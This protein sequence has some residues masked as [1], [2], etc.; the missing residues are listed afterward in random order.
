MQRFFPNRIHYLR[1]QGFRK[2]NPLITIA[3]FTAFRRDKACF[4]T[5]TQYLISTISRPVALLAIFHMSFLPVVLPAQGNCDDSQA[6]VVFI[7]GFL[8]SGD[9]WTTQIQRFASN[10]HCQDRYFAFDWNTLSTAGADARLDLF[11]DSVLSVTGADKIHLVGHSAGG[12]RGYSYLSDPARA[13]KVI[14]Y[15][16]IGSSAESGPAGPNGSTPTLN[17]WSTADAIANGTD[18]PGAENIQFTTFD[19]YQVATSAAT[20]SALYEFF[21][22]MAPGTSEI[23]PETIITIGGRCI[24][25]GENA[26]TTGAMIEVFSV[27]SQG[28]PE[29]D[30]LATFNVTSDGFWGPL[31]V[32]PNTYHLFK[33][34]SA[35]SGFRKVIYYYEPF[36]RDNPTVYLRTFPPALSLA[37][38]LLSAI[39]NSDNQSVISIF[40]STQ[41]VIH[42]RDELS[43]DG[44]DLANA[45]L[46]PASASM[47]A[48]F[49]YDDGGDGQGNG[50]PMGTFAIVPFLQG[51]DVPIAPDPGKTWTIT[52]NGSSIPVRN[53]R[54]K[55]DGVVIAVFNEPKTI[56]NTKSEY[57]GNVRLIIQ[58]NP[59]VDQA[60]LSMGG[61]K[62]NPADISIQDLFGRQL[63]IPITSVSEEELM[64]DITGIPG[65]TYI[66]INHRQ[67]G[68]VTGALLIKP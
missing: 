49:C 2:D 52:F 16:H 24:S 23:E 61:S 45:N 10:G 29:G 48:L 4:M 6:P 56:S 26:A 59:V 68:Q 35:A 30:A 41:A 22:G 17:I 53:W 66:V 7:H 34:T 46:A 31:N 19:H 37:G 67:S 63:S 12:D 44:Y 3:A 9:T 15:A 54:S 40:T 65:G 64:L 43:L 25:L 36:V 39:P 28:E 18:I 38:L 33:V 51:A 32:A 60:R 8:A 11:I 58:P 55:S 5:I 14:S 21:Y 62:L 13:A 50:E 42:G 27:D 1:K 47:I 57:P 20:F